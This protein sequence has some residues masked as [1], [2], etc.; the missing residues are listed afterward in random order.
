MASPNPFE[1]PAAPKAT[2][3]AAPVNPP[4]PPKPAA[5]VPPAAPTAAP[6]A[7]VAA[8]VE[9]VKKARKVPNRQMTADERKFVI[10]N[11]SVMST[12]EIAQH[13]GL[14]RQQVYRT[15]NE[16]RKDLQK[17]ME[18]LQ[19]QPDSPEKKVM[20]DKITALLDKLPSKPFGGGAGAGGKRKGGVNSVLDELLA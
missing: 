16:S 14:T 4:V 15:V 7:P 5:P 10:E 9:G 19:Q 17:R 18:A 3:A 1:K 13:L 2:P 6:A 20:M 11:Y 12:A 8:P